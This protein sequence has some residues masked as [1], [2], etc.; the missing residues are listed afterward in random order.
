MRH[1]FVVAVAV[2]GCATSGNGV[3][4]ATVAA[5]QVQDQTKVRVDAGD[6][7]ETVVRP[8]GIHRQQIRGKR[9]KSTDVTL[10]MEQPAPAPN[11]TTVVQPSMEKHY[12]FKPH[13]YAGVG[14]SCGRLTGCGA[15]LF[16]LSLQFEL[17]PRWRLRLDFSMGLSP[18]RAFGL[19]GAAAA[20]GDVV[21]SKNGKYAF[22][23]GFGAGGAGDLGRFVGYRH[24]DI[25]VEG[26]VGARLRIVELT[27]RPYYA[28][29]NERKPAPGSG[30]TEPRYSAGNFGLFA[31][32]LLRIF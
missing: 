24:F 16:A 19:G 23:L 3:P 25:F 32:L 12:F 13:L 18:T 8:G 7:K 15:D 29:I 1:M 5:A 2:A 14:G 30:S 21:V 22:M 11:T 9:G 10:I 4:P 28:P 27:I 26:V 6:A 20:T 31:N 17:S